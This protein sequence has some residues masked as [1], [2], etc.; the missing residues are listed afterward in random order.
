MKNS[1]NSFLKKVL[2]WWLTVSDKTME[3]LRKNKC[4]FNNSIDYK[5]YVS[6]PSFVSQK[7]FSKDLV[8]IHEIKPVLTLD[9]PI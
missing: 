8:A 4:Y 5:T 2:S 7:F 1:R 6:K 3:N 9:K